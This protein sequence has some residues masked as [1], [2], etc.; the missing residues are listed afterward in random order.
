MPR[1][2]VVLMV[3]RC[4]GA[5]LGFDYTE[6]QQ[7]SGFREPN[8]SLPP[9]YVDYCTVPSS[10]VHR[11]ARRLLSTAGRSPASAVGSSSTESLAPLHHPSAVRSRYGL[12]LI[13]KHA[14]PDAGGK[15]IVGHSGYYP[16][17]RSYA[18]YCPENGVCLSFQLNTSADG[19]VEQ[20]AAALWEVL[21]PLL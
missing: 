17:F 21:L 7:S 5:A 8:S 6:A 1:L 19:L 4:E 13:I 11:I 9:S 10:G 16:G 12:G 15:R 18:F 14:D 20:V 2:W 3:L